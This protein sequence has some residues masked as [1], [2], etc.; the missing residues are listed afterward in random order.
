MVLKRVPKNMAEIPLEQAA[1]VRQNFDKRPE[2]TGVG[3]ANYPDDSLDEQRG[4][5]KLA[6][7][8]NPNPNTESSRKKPLLPITAD[9]FKL[10]QSAAPVVQEKDFIL[11]QKENCPPRS[12]RQVHLNQVNAAPM[13]Q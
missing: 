5:E 11:A 9:P 1:P 6:L 8:I 2:K 3:Q 7:P 13:N 10:P 4:P 12:N